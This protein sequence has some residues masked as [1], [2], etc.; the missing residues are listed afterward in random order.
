MSVKTTQMIQCDHVHTSDG[1]QCTVERP[2]SAI[3]PVEP[4]YHV[5]ITIS[6]LD[7]AGAH[8]LVHED[9]HLC[10]WDLYY[11]LSDYHDQAKADVAA[12]KAQLMALAGDDTPIEQLKAEWADRL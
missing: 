6:V 12:R 9:V 3:N 5:T 2:Q 10:Y 8:Q 7:A 4:M 11:H 1:E